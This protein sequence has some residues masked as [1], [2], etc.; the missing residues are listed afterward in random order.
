MM[1]CLLTEASPMV[2]LSCSATRS[3]TGNS[4]LCSRVASR[5]QRRSRSWA[6]ANLGE[7]AKERARGCA[8]HD[9]QPG[10]AL[11][12]IGRCPVRGIHRQAEYAGGSKRRHRQLFRRWQCCRS[13]RAAR[14]GETKKAR[15]PPILV[16]S[17]PHAPSKKA[18]MRRKGTRGRRR[19][20]CDRGWQ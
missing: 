6:A 7:G 4:Q 19:L 8:S 18:A 16:K 17:K 14:K 11:H 2:P 3:C 12:D 10:C 20:R 9:V 5:V 13:C 15:V 1:G